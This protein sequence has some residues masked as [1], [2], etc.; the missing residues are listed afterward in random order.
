MMPA[1]ALEHFPVERL[2]ESAIAAYRAGK[3]GE[4]EV[5]CKQILKQQPDNIAGLQLLAAVAGQSGAP[6]RGIE[7]IQ[8]VIALQ[9][10]H[11]IDTKP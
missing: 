11:W 6:R 5:R 4:A 3:F 1:E 8:K 10:K 2:L 7:L 9:P